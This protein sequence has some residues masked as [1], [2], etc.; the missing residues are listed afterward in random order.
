[1]HSQDVDQN[2][3]F[4]CACILVVFGMQPCYPTEA[5]LCPVDVSVSPSKCYVESSGALMD[6]QNVQKYG[7][8]PRFGYG[9]DDDDGM[10]AFWDP[11]MILNY[12]KLLSVMFDTEQEQSISS[13]QDASPAGSR[14]VV[15]FLGL[16][17]Q[18]IRKIGGRPTK[19][20]TM[21]MI[22]SVEIDI[23]HM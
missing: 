16:M 20:L 4:G 23:L 15:R 22:A 21:P 9:Y 14:D 11:N 7:L 13:P 10:A 1:M 17:L 19:M 6:M 5:S 18:M 8:Q 12:M 2:N 3:F